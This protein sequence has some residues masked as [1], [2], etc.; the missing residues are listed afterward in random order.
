MR[1]KAA[2]LHR[3]CPGAFLLLER[4][5]FAKERPTPTTAGAPRASPLSRLLPGLSRGTSPARPEKTRATR[6]A[7]RG[8]P[9]PC[10]CPKRQAQPQRA[11]TAFLL[12][13][14]SDQAA[15]PRAPGAFRF[16]ANTA[17]ADTADKG[18]VSV[19]GALPHPDNVS[20]YFRKAL[21]PMDRTP[22]PRRKPI[23]SRDNNETT[24][25]PR[26][27]PRTKT[28]PENQPPL[29]T[30][31]RGLAE[32]V[33]VLSGRAVVLPRKQEPLSMMRPNLSSA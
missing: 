12:G 18:S 28:Q 8:A 21:V 27:S 5:R 3:M 24:K 13:K 19:K 32:L 22:N 16:S 33:G 29:S 2:P 6:G 25:R 9:A 17:S 1:P 26:L 14:Q 23:V 15:H 20:I 7:L 10:G 30:R 11:R 4:S 31:E